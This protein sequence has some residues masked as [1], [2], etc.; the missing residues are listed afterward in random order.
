MTFYAKD[1]ATGNGVD[2]DTVMIDGIASQVSSSGGNITA[3]VPYNRQFSV[4]LVKNNYIE[5]LFSTTANELNGS[6]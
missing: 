4:S 3:L 2:P 1:D 6:T 5:H